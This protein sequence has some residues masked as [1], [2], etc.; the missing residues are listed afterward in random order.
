MHKVPRRWQ[1]CMVCGWYGGVG[2]VLLLMSASCSWYPVVC[3]LLKCGDR[4]AV[5][6]AP[7]CAAPRG[8]LLHPVHRTQ[9]SCASAV[10]LQQASLSI[11]GLQW[12]AGAGAVLLARGKQLCPHC[13]RPMI[14]RVRR[15][16]PEPPAAALLLLEPSRRPEVRKVV[17]LSFLLSQPLAGFCGRKKERKNTP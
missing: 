11:R 8:L 9:R 17:V 5:A 7:N 4:L 16:A 2:H 12:L 1:L 3:L 15:R 10:T 6:F 14:R 13:S